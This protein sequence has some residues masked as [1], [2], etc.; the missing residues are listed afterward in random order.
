MITTEVVWRLTELLSFLTKVVDSNDSLKYELYER[1]SLGIYLGRIL[2]SGNMV[3]KE[4]ALKLLWKLAL[5]KRV[6][7]RIRADLNLYSLLVGLSMNQFNRSKVLIKYANCILFALNSTTY[8]GGGG[9]LPYT[10]LPVPSSVN[11]ISYSSSIRETSTSSS[12]TISSTNSGQQKQQQQ[13]HLFVV[14]DVEYLEI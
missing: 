1:K 11:S 7:D 9:I 5:D 8:E 10:T 2:F 14:D 4:Y 12:R 3:E 13:Q 6:A